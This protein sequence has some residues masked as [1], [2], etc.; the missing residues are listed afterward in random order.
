MVTIF[1]ASVFICPFVSKAQCLPSIAS[2]P[3][4]ESFEASQ[5]G[6]F[7]GGVNNDWAWGAP[8]K[9][10]INA[11][12]T[13]AK[14]WITGG[15]TT[16]FY[17]FGERSWVQ[18]PCFDFSSLVHP[19][20][21][22]KI[23]WETERRFDGGNLQYSI[24]NGTNW[25]NVGAFNDPV[26]CI[27]SNWFNYTPINYLTTLATVRDGW[28]GSTSSSTG[29][30][31]WVIAK[32]CMP[33]LAGQPG[34][35]FRFTFGA[36]TQQNDFDGLAFDDVT[37]REA[38][39]ATPSFTFSCSS[40]NTVSFTDH[41]GMCPNTWNWN[42]GDPGS[43][44]S[45][46]VTTQNAS[47][48]FSAPG[49]YNVTLSASNTC[50]ALTSTFQIVNIMNATAVATDVSCFGGSDGSATIQLSGGGSGF[51][52]HWNTTPVQSAITATGL[53]SGTYS[54]YVTGS[55]VCPDTNTVTIN[56]PTQINHSLAIVEAHCGLNNGAASEAVNGGTPAYHY[57]W[58]SG[59]GDFPTTSGLAPGNYSVTVTDSKGCSVI[60]NFNITS[61][62]PFSSSLAV[63]QA[64]CGLNNGKAIA[65]PVGGTLP[66]SYSWT[67][68]VSGNNTAN[69]LGSGS[70]IVTITDS[71]GCVD[72]D[73]ATIILQPGVII[74]P[75]FFSDTCDRGVGLAYVNVI[76][77]TSP[78]TY[79]WNPGIINSSI[80]SSLVSGDYTITVTDSN[81]CTKSQD[82]H[83]GDY[84]SFS[85]SLGD[86]TTIC[87]GNQLTLSTGNY[88]SYLWQDGSTLSSL[89]IDSPGTYWVTIANS[90]GC[91]STDTIVV[92]EECL[93]DVVL[94]SA[95][96]P[97]GDGR[98]DFFFASGI[99][100]TSFNLKIFNRWGEKIFE[101]DDISTPWTGFYKG[102]AQ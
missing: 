13:G 22:F 18:S 89:T 73:T 98:N 100:V 4:N 81:S 72:K 101:T 86:N 75:V 19:Y 88:Q 53:P 8:T 52:Y 39:P 61:P 24:D 10:I 35:L 3:Y 76:S 58:S 43:G 95:F 1:V 29:S 26:N 32:H 99:N 77:G 96:T 92:K 79:Q 56:Q 14:C 51:S 90:L 20:I 30:N 16:P 78:F 27:D 11:A 93:D 6:W 74:S 85:F 40:T 44:G 69:N 84:G 70:Y 9:P 67:P 65:T 7:S 94:P 25:V 12:G 23:F 31:G 38:P 41:T 71:S 21:S 64:T 49:S 91:V 68:S 57:N 37:I 97:N 80:I 60:D 47:H 54:F 46:L 28:S 83:I 34:V 87:T 63:Q 55:N 62:L 50:S 48:T 42:F 36:G 66:Y 82:V 17:N 33:Y 2:F 5:G 45:N 59:T 15:L 102:R